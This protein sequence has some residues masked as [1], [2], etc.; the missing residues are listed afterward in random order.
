MNGKHVMKKICLLIVLTGGIAFSQQK[1]NLTV[2]I[3]NIQSS[4]G[5]ILIALYNNA[6]SFPKGLPTQKVSIPSKGNTFQYTFKDISD[7]QYAIAVLHDENKNKKMDIGVLG[8]KEAY[9]FSNNARG[10][11]APPNYKDA[12]FSIHGEDKIVSIILK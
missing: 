4:K 2:E 1:S 10:V 3:K 11:L 6:K 9:G 8:P 5:N 12:A 7:G